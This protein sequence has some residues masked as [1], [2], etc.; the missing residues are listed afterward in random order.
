M[1]L[2]MPGTRWTPAV[3]EAGANV[4][5]DNAELALEGDALAPVSEPDPRFPVK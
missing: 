2:I 5:E 4:L 3:W 1:A